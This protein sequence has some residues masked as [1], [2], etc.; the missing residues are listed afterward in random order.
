MG[1]QDGM[2]EADPLSL[3]VIA[4]ITVAV[5]MVILWFVQRKT[6]RGCWVVCGADRRCAL[7]YHASPS[8]N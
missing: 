1:M 8:W 6:N 5:L 7:V 2:D 3:V 4:Y